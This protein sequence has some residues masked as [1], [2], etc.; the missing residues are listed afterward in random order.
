MSPRV[1]RC[2]VVEVPETRPGVPD[3]VAGPKDVLPWA[4]PYIAALLTSRRLQ[5][6]LDDS[7]RFIEHE[8]EEDWRLPVGEDR[9]TN[10]DWRLPCGE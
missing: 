2:V 7:L 9:L 5:A 3:L 8:Q 4:D 1:A 6:A 10:G